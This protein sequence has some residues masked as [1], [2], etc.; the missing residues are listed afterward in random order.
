MTATRLAVMN[1]GHKAPLKHAQIQAAVLRRRVLLGSRPLRP[2][3]AL[4]PFSVSSL[5]RW[6]VHGSPSS[7]RWSRTSMVCAEQAPRHRA[8]PSKLHSQLRWTAAI[9]SSCSV[10]VPFHTTLATRR[11]LLCDTGCG[12]R[13][14]RRCPNVG[15]LE[16]IRHEFP[17]CTPDAGWS[18]AKASAPSRSPAV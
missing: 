11:C 16:L 7:A 12:L 13:R 2:H 17:S 1:S 6:R 10:K 3:G 18:C 9:R 4:I 14:D 5:T 15:A 8:M